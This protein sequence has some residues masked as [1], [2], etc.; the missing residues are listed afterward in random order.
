MLAADSNPVPKGEPAMYSPC[1]GMASRSGNVATLAIVER[2]SVTVTGVVQA[3]KE[4]TVSAYA[5]TNR[6]CATPS[7]SPGSPRS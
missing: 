3:V 6:V 1:S 4:R 7:R 5:S 2:K